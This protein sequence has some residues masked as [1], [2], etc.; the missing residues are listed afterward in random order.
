MTDP[1]WKRGK[2]RKTEMDVEKRAEMAM[3][4]WAGDRRR[5]ASEAWC[6]SI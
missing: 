6:H 5:G 4:M 2:D 3:H 1:G